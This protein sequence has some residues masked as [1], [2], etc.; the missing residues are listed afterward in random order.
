MRRNIEVI[1][2]T[3]ETLT[4]I[5]RD[6]CDDDRVELAVT[7]EVEDPEALAR[8]ALRGEFCKVVTLAH[9]PVFAFGA[10]RCQP[11]T[12]V[13]WGFKTPQGRAVIRTVTKYIKRRLI[14]DL[15]AI[16]ISHGMCLVHPDNKYS[17]RWL[18]HLGYYPLG[19]TT[20]I[21]TRQ[22]MI[23]YRY[24]DDAPDQAGRAAAA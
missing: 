21:G 11:A 24:D 22:P 4:S 10:W 9:E 17:Q 13:V 15:R 23:I 5:A 2:G 18:S 12:A 20:D 14:P 8:D 19:Q 6:L 16:G 1:D 7:R 3:L